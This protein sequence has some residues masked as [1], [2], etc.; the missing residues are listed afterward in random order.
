MD[1]RVLAAA[2]LLIVSACGDSA[3]PGRTQPPVANEPPPPA[4]DATEPDSA[5]PAAE[6]E[7]A[8][9]EDMPSPGE[10]LPVPFRKI[11]EPWFGDWDGMIER[12]LVRAVVPFGGYHFYY[13]AG[14]PRG[15]TWELLQRLEQHI[16]DT[17]KRR[18]IKI[19]VV[20]IPVNRDE[21]IPALLDGHADLIAADLTITDDRAAQL[22]FSRPWLTNVDEVI[23]TH[24]DVGGIEGLD[25]LAGREIVVRES[26]SY[27]EHLQ[28]VLQDYARR[29]LEPPTIR[30]ADEILEAE[31]LL[32]LLNAGIIDITVLD[33]YKAEFW[34]ACFRTFASWTTLSST[35]V[36]RSAGQCARI[37]PSSHWPSKATCSD[38]VKA[39]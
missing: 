2:L 32:D 5:A 15:A 18:N 9:L 24:K 1:I 23:V 20:A 6:A 37:I 19:Y 8:E 38:T 16:N 36:E 28:P 33:R 13:D 25:D 35:T 14:V 34:P 10:L 27:Y 7:P 29:G 17:L 31:D 3:E 26:S 39:L 12:R 4:S 11:W 22:Q 30:A 21:L